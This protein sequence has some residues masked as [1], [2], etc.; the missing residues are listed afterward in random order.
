MSSVVS[1]YL[2]NSILTAYLP[3]TY[4]SLHSDLTGLTGEFE[5]S[6]GEY[7]RQAIIWTTP[8]NKTAANAG[9]I[10]FKNL[11]P[12]SLLAYGVW[13][14]LIG[15]N[16]L[17]GFGLPALVNILSADDWIIPVNEFAITF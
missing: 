2:G 16:F 1:N 17:F 12:T 15:G 9:E 6:G 4:L 5:I 7:A 3:G 10:K 14:S 11:L 13:D 8:S